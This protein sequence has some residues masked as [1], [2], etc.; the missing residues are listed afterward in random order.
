[1]SDD[2]ST[3]VAILDRA[4]S[5]RLHPVV[6]AAM[7]HGPDPATLRELLAVQRE[8]EAGES[9]RQYTE[10]LVALKRDLPTVL[11]RDQT[12]VFGKTRYTHT[13]LAAVMEA[14][15]GPLTSHGFALSWEPSTS[16]ATVTVAC[17]LT[18]AGGHSERAAISAPRDN[19]GSKSAS[20]GVASTIT[21]LQRYSAL[22][23]LGIATA[24]MEEPTGTAPD[25]DRVDSD[26][27]LRLVGNLKN[28]GKTRQDA[29]EFLG[30]RVPK[31]TAGDLENLASWLKS[32]KYKD[33]G[34]PP[35]G[36]DV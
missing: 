3:A 33:V 19:S 35:M 8:W 27:N 6:A 14:V 12:V 22:S 20:Q 11:A 1:M 5:E 34:P 21:L 36:D 31:W 13:S 15:T 29:E 23:L 2:H 4:D 18:H 30:K 32:E 26:R 17:V 9:K 25:P 24:D 10:A 28:Y 16:D 7:Q